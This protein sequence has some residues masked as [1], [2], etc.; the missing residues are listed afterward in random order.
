MALSEGEGE[1][2][3]SLREAYTLSVGLLLC[4]ELF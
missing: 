4:L 1:E 3:L 2:F